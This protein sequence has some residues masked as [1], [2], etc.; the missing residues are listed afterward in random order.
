MAMK[1]RTHF[2]F[3][4]DN[5]RQTAK[6][7]SNTSLA[8]KITK[9]QSL[10]SAPPASVGPVVARLR[11][12]SI[13]AIGLEASGGYER[14]DSTLPIVFAQVSDPVAAGLVASPARPGGNVTGFALWEYGF[15]AKWGEVLR[16]IAPR[17]VRI[18][19]I[20]D[21]ANAMQRHLPDLERTLS[22]GAVYGMRLGA[23]FFHSADDV[24]D[25]LTLVRAGATGH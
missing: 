12:F 15:A 8:S 24:R 19:V 25:D 23:R 18:G 1:T 10:P 2:T 21:P 7:L 4:V 3:R 11:N 20:Y 17:T 22:P 9:S 6:A 16:E 14:G 13:M 5:G